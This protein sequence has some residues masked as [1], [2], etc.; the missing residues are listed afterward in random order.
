MTTSTTTQGTQGVNQTPG[1]ATNVTGTETA[2]NANT[3]PSTPSTAGLLNAALNAAAPQTATPTPPPAAPTVTA[4]TYNPT[5]ANGGL[6]DPSKIP[7]AGT[8]NANATSWTVD[9]NQLAS[10]QLQNILSSSSPLMAQASLQGDQSAAARGLLNSS[11]AGGAEQQAMIQNAAPIA[12]SNA[13]TYGA[14]A[15]Q[16]AQEATNVSMANAAAA[17]AAAQQQAASQA[18]SMNQN[19]ATI[20]NMMQWTASANLTAQQSNAANTLSRN[21]SIYQT[22]ASIAEQNT[23][24]QA[25]NILQKIVT[26]GSLVLGAN[27]N[28]NSQLTNVMNMLNSALNNPNITNPVASVLPAIQLLQTQTQDLAPIIGTGSANSYMA[29]IN[30]YLPATPTSAVPGETSTN[31]VQ[32][33]PATPVS[34]SGT[35]GGAAN[36][37]AQMSFSQWLAANPNAGNGQAAYGAYR[38]AGGTGGIY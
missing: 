15:S 27:S 24:V 37:A 30:Q 11:I 9:P 19:A 16:N 25:A 29:S 32:P 33:N 5:V 1:A 14:A 18:A 31:T 7:L 34:P 26:E 28:L 3:P 13:S 2:A 21:L 4:P 36:N 23:S 6:V 17:N 35:P 22:N 8:T 12:Q 38:A 20:S 10:T